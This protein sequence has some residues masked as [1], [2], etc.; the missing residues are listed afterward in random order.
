MISL[1]GYI[2]NKK[3]SEYIVQALKSLE[4]RG[5]D[6]SGIERSSKRT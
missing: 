2:G 3:A 1:V 4:Y 5:Y 6:F